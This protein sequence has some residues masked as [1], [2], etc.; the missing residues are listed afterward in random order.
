MAENVT[1][2][3]LAIDGFAEREVMMVDYKLAD[4]LDARSDEP[5]ECLSEVREHR[6]R[7]SHEGTEGYQLLLHRLHREV[8][9]RSAAL[10]ADRDRLPEARE[11][12]RRIRQ[13]LE[14]G[15]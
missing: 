6:R 1:P 5:E 13:S 2:V 12:L 10:R 11:R 8:G 3:V 14:V 7:C 4:R 9:R 15:D